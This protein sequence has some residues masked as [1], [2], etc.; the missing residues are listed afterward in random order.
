MESRIW[1]LLG[2]I[3][4]C[5]GSVF[6]D[7]ITPK[8]IEPLK[9]EL[10]A[11]YQVVL[12][13]ID[14]PQLQTANPFRI[15]TWTTS[16]TKTPLPILVVVQQKSQ[17][18]AWSLPLVV[19][20]SILGKST[21][22]VKASETLCHDFMRNII[23]DFDILLGHTG[24]LEVSQ[25]F[26]ISLST[27]SPQNVTIHLEL[28]EEKNFYVN[29]GHK[30]SLLVSPSEPRYVF[31]KFNENTSDTI[32]IEVDSEDDV[33]LIVSVQDSRCP[34]M[35]MNKDIKYEGTYQTVNLK[36]AITVP[37]RNFNEGF[38]LVFV[39]RPDNFDCSEESSLLPRIMSTPV[40][41]MKTTSN[42]T[43]TVRN[44]INVKQYRIGVFATL[45][46]LVAVGL[47]CIILNIAFNRFGTIS[48][49]D[50]KTETDAPDGFP[51]FRRSEQIAR[52]LSNGSL[53]VADFSTDP[54]RIKRRSFNYL[55]H[56]LS[57]AIFYSIPV[58]QLVVTYQR[59][60]NKTGNED[61]CYYNFLC[62]HPAFGFSDFNHIYSNIGYIVFGIIFIFAVVDR[63]SVI[64]LRVDRGIAVHYGLFHAMGLALIIEGV[65]SACYHICPSQSSYQFDTSFMY[66]MA[67]LCM[68]KL[69]QNRHP[70][71]NATAYTTFT[72][73][74][75]AIFLA[76]LGILNANMFI[77]IIFF[78]CYAT[79]TVIVSLKIYFLNFVLDGLTQFKNNVEKKGFC[80]EALKPIRK[81]RFI[82]LLIAN[83][84]NYAM[85]ITGFYLYT[86][87]LTDFGTFLLG[88][89]MGN[90]VIHT[91]FYT[92]MKKVIHKE[93]IC[94]EAIIYG[95][96]SILCW[97]ASGYFFL[98]AAT[99]WTVTP[100][101]SR[102]WNQKCILIDFFD[103]HDVWHLL[104]APAL[105]FTFMYLMCLD[106]DII[107][108]YQTELPVF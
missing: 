39:A 107:D 78:I 72:V 76:M 56:T 2:M 57:V 53:T 46:T 20:T 22:F 43:F 52:L 62:A 40:T 50:R 48:K 77:W 47:L 17:V 104:S 34:V 12:S 93:K 88:L 13:Y 4:T 69:Y 45:G 18:S 74:G 9:F 66:V 96:L 101:E 97:G 28:E 71:I 65:L 15:K 75:G 26:I 55:S 23:N 59:I 49:T 25:C 85:L 94:F 37:K 90:A 103:R 19:E 100:A 36:G 73:L 24:T 29:L 14:I 60:V 86:K 27:S 106:D 10:N 79:L 16:D 80:T 31:Y 8:V 87:G 64:K 44:G 89:L 92:V 11:T 41:D 61:M 68:I 35:D 98:D 67:V 5:L 108:K 30:Y 91:I 6:I 95:I 7:Q 84:V 21:E 81:T 70:E 82:V 58:V 51:A 102:Q 63:H 54:K 42:V 99:L 83:V 33:C 105:Y 32:V 3:S 38:F 1:I